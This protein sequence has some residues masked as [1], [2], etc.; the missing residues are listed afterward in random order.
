MI[1][2][3]EKPAHPP[4]PTSNTLK[5]EV[6]DLTSSTHQVELNSHGF[7]EPDMTLQIKPEIS[8]RIESID[9]AFTV[10]QF[11]KKGQL[12]ASI[13]TLDYEAELAKAEAD[14]AKA[15]LALTKELGASHVANKQL[16]GLAGKHTDYA[17]HKPQLAHKYAEF[18]AKQAALKQAQYELKQ[19]Q[20]RAPFNGIITSRELAL[21]QYVNTTTQLGQLLG[22]DQANIRLP[23]HQEDLKLMPTHYP[24]HVRLTDTKSG[25]TWQAQINA[26]THTVDQKSRM[27][28][29]IATVNQPYAQTT[30][31][32]L[33]TF[34][35]ASIMSRP[36]EQTLAIPQHLVNN[37]KIH[38]L[39]QDN[40][41]MIHP[42]TPLH[43]DNEFVYISNNSNISHQL[44]STHIEQAKQGMSCEPM[45]KDTSHAEIAQKNETTQSTSITQ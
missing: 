6:I 15:K 30:E 32:P 4:K 38:L 33:Y 19:T 37:R 9:P 2:T 14:L 31:L 41:L 7:V 45:S 40:T 28:Y 34:V 13:H 1:L 25:R 20:I 17:L 43:R 23:I 12:L 5:V 18:K 35:Q 44:I 21:G 26:Q 22:T 39:S 24:I 10:G 36:L 29:F 11:V 16:E 42:I 27:T 3:N 8:G